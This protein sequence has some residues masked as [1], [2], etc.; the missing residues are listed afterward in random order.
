MFFL[1]TLVY[2]LGDFKL[3]SQEPTGKFGYKAGARVYLREFTEEMCKMGFSLDHSWE[4]FV[5]IQRIVSYFGVCFYL[6]ISIFL[7]CSSV[8]HGNIKILS[9][10][11]KLF[12]PYTFLL[13]LVGRKCHV[14]QE[15]WQDL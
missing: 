14:Y 5:G 10:K 2:C 7:L 13:Y 1:G 8:C 9:S 6:L 11:R 15:K 4:I 12:L 3:S